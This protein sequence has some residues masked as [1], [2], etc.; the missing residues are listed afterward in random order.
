MNTLSSWITEERKKARASYKKRSRGEAFD[1]FSSREP[2]LFFQNSQPRKKEEGVEKKTKKMKFRVQA[3]LPLPADVYFL[4]RDSAAFRALLA[5]V[6]VEERG[7]E[8]RSRGFLRRKK[9][10]KTVKG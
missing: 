9:V 1:L 7:K 6:R 5:R 3:T 8:P 2:R 10:K 4:E